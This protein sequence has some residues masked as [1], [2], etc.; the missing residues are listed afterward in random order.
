MLTLQS[1]ASKWQL[2]PVTFKQ[3]ITLAQHLIP[4]LFKQHITLAQPTPW[5]LV[6]QGLTTPYCTATHNGAPIGIPHPTHQEAPL[7]LT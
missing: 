4:K 5:Q 1:K 6:S 2:C 3:H 7:H